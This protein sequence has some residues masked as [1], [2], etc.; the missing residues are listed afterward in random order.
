MRILADENMMPET[1][2]GLRDDGH[3]VDWANE[4][5]SGA[6]DTNLLDIA[7]ADGR[8]L[9]TYDK[10]YGELVHRFGA[11][12]PFGVIL[13]RIYDDLPQEAEIRFIV[14]SV[15]IRDDWPPG[16]W[17]IQIRHRG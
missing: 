11:A 5:Y 17:T 16:I 15:T 13:F 1:V 2:V 6:P 10:D 9:I 12:A 14:N 3:D 8:L 4:I 7:T